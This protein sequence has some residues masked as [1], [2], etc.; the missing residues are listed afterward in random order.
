MDDLRELATKS[1]VVEKLED[2]IKCWCKKLSDILKESEQ[3]RKENHSSG[4]KKT[5]MRSI[6][7]MSS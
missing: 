5:K 4:K 6:V 7:T 1:D 2:R 3:I